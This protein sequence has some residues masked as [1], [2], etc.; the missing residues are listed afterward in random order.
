MCLL[1]V[2]PPNW[3][4]EGPYFSEYE[5]WGL[6]PGFVSNIEDWKLTHHQPLYWSSWDLFNFL[7]SILWYW[8]HWSTINPFGSLHKKQEIQSVQKRRSKSPSSN[9]TLLSLYPPHSLHN[10]NHIASLIF[11]QFQVREKSKGWPTQGLT[12][13]MIAQMF[14]TKRLSETIKHVLTKMVGPR[15]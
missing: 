8:S 7:L 4:T 6:P 5:D 12:M 15:L 13:D 11:M 1:W 3:V 14:E 10:L 9:S 2:S